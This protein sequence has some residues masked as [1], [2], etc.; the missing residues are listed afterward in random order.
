MSYLVLLTV[1]ER[2]RSLYLLLETPKSL[3]LSALGKTEAFAKYKP[4]PSVP[5]TLIVPAAAEN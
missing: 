2:C 1:P 3:T 4:L 5:L